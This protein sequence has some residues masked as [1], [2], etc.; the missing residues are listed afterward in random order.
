M[1]AVETAVRNGK[2]HDQESNDSMMIY[3]IENTIPT[4]PGEPS[5][6]HHSQE[7]LFKKEEGDQAK[8]GYNNIIHY[9]PQ[10]IIYLKYVPRRKKNAVC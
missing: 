3:V 2:K 5:L 8:S 4:Y 1:E 6:L 9:W 10:E 7:L